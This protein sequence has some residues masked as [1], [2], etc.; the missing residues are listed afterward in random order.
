MHG[1]TRPRRPGLSRPGLSPWFAIAVAV[2]I[3]AGCT[4]IGEVS[5]PAS[6]EPSAPEQTA[7]GQTSPSPQE[8]P[9]ASPLAGQA[10]PAPSGSATTSATASAIV[11]GAVNR[12]SIRLVATYDVNATVHYW[13]RRVSAVS[14]MSVRNASGG[15]IDRVELNTVTAR[16]GSLRLGSVTVDGRTVSPSI[17]DQTILVPLGGTLP[18]GAT[19]SVGIVFR[20]TLRSD[21]SGS[22]WLFTRTN[23]II[24]ANRWLPW[25]SLRRPF[26]RPN[27]GEPFYTA[28]SPY[29]RFRVTTDRTLR[30]A[31]AG[32]RVATSGLTQTFEARDVRDFNFAA[33][34]FYSV[35]SATVGNTI[36]RVFYKSGYPVSTVLGYAKSAIARMGALVGTY[37]F[38]F[39]TVAQSAGAYGMESP[40]M[41]WI[42]GGLSG[43]HLRWLVH[44][45]TAHQW[46]YG[47]VGSDQAYQP[48][49]DEG[50]ADHLARYVTGI[51]RSSRCS[52]ARLDLTIYRYSS[53][54]YFEII[55]IQG[56]AFLDGIRRRMG[57]T[58]YW[59]AM[60]DY[61]AARRFGL[62]S[63]P[64]LLSNLDAH[65]T[66]DLRATFA[67]RFPRF[68]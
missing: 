19:A 28:S 27:H 57:T 20:A 23:G 16:I 15:P 62:G 13:D 64:A 10:S 45:E 38:R 50:A 66:L 63:T 30:F 34:P 53:T 61:V 67:R 6:A 37:P 51:W 48:F 1:P 54:C 8:A 11:P 46:F 40:Q 2:A 36:V 65:T 4:A 58:A 18:D 55:Y 12:T 43:S 26:N 25:I 14:V 24:D 47:I 21:L 52:T 17:S 22:N 29:V 59:H 56:S 32:R 31:T 49:A 41:I 35:R 39:F 3:V 7:T 42:P 33:S 9:T 68:Y 5:S 60:R 44:H